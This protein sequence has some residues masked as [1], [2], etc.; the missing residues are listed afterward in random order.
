[1]SDDNVDTPKKTA[2]FKTL[3]D[4]AQTPTSDASSKKSKGHQNSSQS[5][6][7]VTT[8]INRSKSFLNRFDNPKMKTKK[9]RKSKEEDEDPH[10]AAVFKADF[11]SQALSPVREGDNLD[12][13]ETLSS[14]EGNDGNNEESTQAP[15]DATDGEEIPQ[16]VSLCPWCGE[17]VDHDLL[18]KFSKGER[19][20]VRLQT[21]FCQQHKKH[22][23]RQTWLSK[24]YPTIDWE[25]LPL[26]IMSHHD[27]LLDI[28][29]G[30]ESYYRSRLAEKI[31]EG[32][33]RS[34]KK[35]ENLNPGYYGP[36]GFN[37]MCDR[38]VD[39][40]SNLLKEKAV[41]DRVISGRGSAAF[42]QSVLVAELA[43]LLIMEDMGVPYDEARDIMEESKAIGEIVN[44]EG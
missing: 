28:V 30:E 7:T 17:E 29:D 27:A 12:M 25:E 24:S 26:R 36:R 22:T 14:D 10:A 6:Q 39:R 33:S 11:D 13:E 37:L 8:T 9:R 44:E 21:K 35:E 3:P 15:E 4:E 42:I 38:L 20:N 41:K 18:R 23:A 16:P 5:S 43:T 31:K 1:M 2:K 40:F 32:T 34:M 19:M